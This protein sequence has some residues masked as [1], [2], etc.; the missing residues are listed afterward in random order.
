MHKCTRKHS[1]TQL[2][3]EWDVLHRRYTD[4][5]SSRR[6]SAD[7]DTESFKSKSA[8]FKKSGSYDQCYTS[9]EEFS[10]SLPLP[11]TKDKDKRLGSGSSQSNLGSSPERPANIPKYI[12]VERKEVHKEEEE[13]YDDFIDEEMLKPPPGK[14]KQLQ[15][16]EDTKLTV[17]KSEEPQMKPEQDVDISAHYEVPD[18]KVAAQSHDDMHDKPNGEEEEQH[19]PYANWDVAQANSIATRVNASPV[20]SPV[21]KTSNVPKK[22][23]PIQRKRTPVEDVPDPDS[24]PLST[25][26]SATVKNLPKK[27]LPPQK[28]RKLIASPGSTTQSSPKHKGLASS[29]SLPSVSSEKVN[30]GEESVQKSSESSKAL[31]GDGPMTGPV[32]GLLSSKSVVNLGASLGETKPR[33][34][35]TVEQLASPDKKQPMLPPAS[36]LRSKSPS[37]SNPNT[38]QSTPTDDPTPTAAQLSSKVSSKTANEPVR[39]RAYTS[40]SVV[41]PSSS[42]PKPPQ[43]QKM[44]SVA[45]AT[46]VS[47]VSKA[48]ASAVSA[49]GVSRLI[50]GK[51]STPI[52]SDQA[53]SGGQ[54]E[55]G[56]DELM[57]K[58]SLRRQRIEQQTTLIKPNA[59]VGKIAEAGSERNSTIST[60]SSH[61]EVVVAY[62][63]IEGSSS[64][65]SLSSNSTGVTGHSDG[66]SSNSVL[67]LRKQQTSPEKDGG[68][69][70][71]YG[72]IED[73]DGG[74]YVI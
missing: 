30:A 24:K 65:T 53:S 55:K 52:I 61:S 31:K 70:A 29:T 25:T 34:H 15:N 18:V 5:L 1:H 42:T 58:L 57:R 74:S 59:S 46:P 12:N 21:K 45:D 4:R 40:S 7:K 47:N 20:P 60:S 8:T 35:T 26:V 33:S 51:K 72:I 43:L 16:Y 6:H 62:R 66:G 54:K 48:V 22:P 27:P 67:E 49:V 3:E 2:A 23:M 71:K 13:E 39:M 37:P 44:S 56:K 32:K 64:M 41:N 69:L 36:R 14:A 73:V 10:T 50:A 17:K 68:N 38:S 19:H 28:P 9:S 11:H 63:R